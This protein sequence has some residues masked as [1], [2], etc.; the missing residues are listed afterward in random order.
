[1][2]MVCTQC[3]YLILSSTYIPYFPYTY[4]GELKRYDCIDSG[5]GGKRPGNAR[6]T[7]DINP[8]YC[9]ASAVCTLSDGSVLADP[10]TCP[11]TGATCTEGS[12]IGN[13]TKR[14][15]N[16]YINKHRNCLGGAGIQCSREQPCDPC[17]RNS[18]NLFGSKFSHSRNPQNLFLIRELF[19]Y[20]FRHNFLMI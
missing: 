19:I 10:T 14:I 9:H 11:T 12:D 13:F 20:V 7:Y 15:I 1:M 18:L 2:L 4:N 17:D 5:K 16:P 8:C 6:E 3:Y